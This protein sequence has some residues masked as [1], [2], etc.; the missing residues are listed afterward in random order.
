MLDFLGRFHDRLTAAGFACAA[1][2]VGIISVSFWYEVVSRYFFS[3]P[4]IW[5]YAVAS[6]ALCAMIFLA[7][8]AMSKQ[9][10]HICVSYLVDKL[11]SERR[12]NLAKLI[13]LVAALMCFACAFIAAQ[14]TWRQYV[15]QIETISG[16]PVPKWWVSIFIP[17]GM[18][19]SAFHFLRQVFAGAPASAPLEAP[20]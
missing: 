12:R 14:E 3:S 16:F 9:G 13:L 6:Y 8:P 11:P 18:L 2:F 20:P 1:G 19:V 4:T 7:M 17:Y 10:A 15:Q 5:A